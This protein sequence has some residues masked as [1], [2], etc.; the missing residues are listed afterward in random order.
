MGTKSD[1]KKWKVSVF[2]I[3]TILRIENVQK[4]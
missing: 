1:E 2:T 4:S 3:F